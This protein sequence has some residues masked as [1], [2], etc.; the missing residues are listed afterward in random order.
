MHNQNLQA[1]EELTDHPIP[2]IRL[3][4]AFNSAYGRCDEAPTQALAH[5]RCDRACRDL[6]QERGHF[7]R[8]SGPV[9]LSLLQP[10]PQRG[11][12]QIQVL[13]DLRY[14]PG[15]PHQADRVRF[16]LRRVRPSFPLCHVEHPGADR[17]GW[18]VR[19]GR[20]R[21]YLGTLDVEVDPGVFHP[22]TSFLRRWNGNPVRIWGNAAPSLCRERIAAGHY[23]F[24]S[25]PADAE[26]E[27]VWTGT[28]GEERRQNV[29]IHGGAPKRVV[30]N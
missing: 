12:R 23:R 6:G 16:L 24:L 13:R 27:F 14:A 20:A 5:L 2:A 17:A 11:L 22:P 28:K 21:S 19:S 26:I 15:L 9:D 29:S 8:S 10:V 3:A 4:A 30:L 1:P 25:I 7:W 18:G